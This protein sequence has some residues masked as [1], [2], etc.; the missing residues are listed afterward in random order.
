MKTT[1]LLLGL[2][3][4]LTAGGATML[5]AG[6]AV[7][8]DVTVVAHTD[9]DLPVARVSFA[10]LNLADAGGQHVLRRRVGGA[11]RT[12]CAPAYDGT[13]NLRFNDCRNQAWDE[14]KPQMTAAIARATR[15]AAGTAS[16]GDR[17]LALNGT[18]QLGGR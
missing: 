16:A 4:V 12:V 15:L 11:I 2:A 5:A 9:G 10:D 7:A 3:A 17:A 8:R 18:I 14:A 13:E 6:P 1:N